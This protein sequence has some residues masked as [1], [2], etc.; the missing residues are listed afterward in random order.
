MKKLYNWF[1]YKGLRM[2]RRLFQHRN[3]V[4]VHKGPY[5]PETAPTCKIEKYSSF[6]ELPENVKKAFLSSGGHDVMEINRVELENNAVLYVGYI[7]DKV[8]GV[9]FSRQGKYFKR[10]FV[11]LAD[12]DIVLF[13]A[14]TYPEFRGRGI[15]PT[16][17]RYAMHDNLF[18]TS[19]FA[20]ADCRVY[21]TASERAITKAGFQKI[22]VM[23]PLRQKDV[24]K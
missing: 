20:Y 7:D 24:F 11:D 14:K 6:A 10:W 4:F 12:N 1:Y 22:G 21:N 15:C 17:I 16:L 13:R 18:N 2:Y 3:Y 19:N 8:A 23:K 9:L 5:N